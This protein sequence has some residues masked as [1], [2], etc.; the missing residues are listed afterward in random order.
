MA[1]CKALQAHGP[2]D[3]LAR[4]QVHQPPPNTATHPLDVVMSE[5]PGPLDLGPF[6]LA[7]EH[8]LSW[9]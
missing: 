7:I 4:I 6:K 2:A 1:I 3:D 8:L 5:N 9:N